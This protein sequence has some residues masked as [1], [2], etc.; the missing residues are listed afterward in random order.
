MTKLKYS[1]HVIP[2]QLHDNGILA[3]SSA[4]TVS[5]VLESIRFYADRHILSSDYLY[6]FFFFVF[7]SFARLGVG[8]SP[9]TGSICYACCDTLTTGTTILSGSCNIKET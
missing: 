4:D 8:L 7:P 2:A 6:F 1:V 5:M 9:C 3:V